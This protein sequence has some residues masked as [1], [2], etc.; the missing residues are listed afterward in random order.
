M[1]Y[2]GSTAQPALNGILPALSVV[3]PF[4]NEGPNIASLL[5]EL[6]EALER[7]GVTHE[8]LAVD[9][10]S[11]DDTAAALAAAARDWPAVRVISFAKNRGQAAALWTGFREARGAWIASLDGDGQNPPSELPRL[12]EQ[13]ESADLIT[14]RRARRND[15]WLRRTMSRVANGVRRRLLRD[16]VDDSGCALRLFRREVRE[17]FWPIRTLYSFIPA[18]AA[19]GGW[20]IRQVDVAHRARKAGTSKYGLLVM[21]WRPLCDMLALFWLLRRQLPQA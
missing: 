4:F 6:R 21:A 10:G 5:A 12:W 17:S 1:D 13:R 2:V 11:A 20:R 18:F 8:V 3:I 14:G 9:D 7:L 16:G 15:S 19:A